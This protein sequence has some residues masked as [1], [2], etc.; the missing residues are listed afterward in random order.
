MKKGHTTKFTMVTTFSF[1]TDTNVG[2]GTASIRDTGKLSVIAAKRRVLDI[3]PPSAPSMALT[4]ALTLALLRLSP[5]MKQQLLD[6]ALSTNR[7]RVLPESLI[8]W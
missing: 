6:A 1:K 3:P 4:D 8:S 7:P 2:Q 5:E